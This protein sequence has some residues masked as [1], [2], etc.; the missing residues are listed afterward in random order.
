MSRVA[1]FSACGPPVLRSRVLWNG[2]TQ[3]PRGSGTQTPARDSV[4]ARIRA[5]VGVEGAVLLHDHDD[6]LDLVDV[7]VRRG[8]RFSPLDAAT[9]DATTAAQSTTPTTRLTPR[10][11]AKAI[12]RR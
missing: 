5:E 1:F 9:P 4:G 12:G 8:G 6:V 11:G 2:L 10:I 7:G 3:P